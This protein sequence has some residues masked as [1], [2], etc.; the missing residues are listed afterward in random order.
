MIDELVN[1]VI[2]VWE[3]LDIASLTKGRLAEAI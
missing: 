3:A 1:A 2:E